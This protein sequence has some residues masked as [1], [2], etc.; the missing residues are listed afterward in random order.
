MEASIKDPEDISNV[1]YMGI[2]KWRKKIIQNTKSTS[3]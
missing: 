3:F 1:K 2:S